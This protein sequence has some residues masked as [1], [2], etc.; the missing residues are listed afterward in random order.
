MA[1]VNPGGGSGVLIVV[2]GPDLG[3]IVRRTERHDAAHFDVRQTLGD[4]VGG[5][6]DESG[7]R[8]PVPIRTVG[9]DLVVG[10]TREVRAY[11]Q[12]HG[13]GDIPQV[14]DIGEDVQ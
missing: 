9:P 10:L 8:T 6:A 14:T 13:R 1:A 12:E 11:F 7:F 3:N 5:A 4:R 2:V